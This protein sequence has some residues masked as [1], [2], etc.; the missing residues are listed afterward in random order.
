MFVARSALL[1]ELPAPR[2]RG[3]AEH[4]QGRLMSTAPGA[5][6]YIN[7]TAVLSSSDTAIFWGGLLWRP[8]SGARTSA[9]IRSVMT[10]MPFV[11]P[12]IACSK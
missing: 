7:D 3:E 9:A 1:R 12:L 10:P 11:R 6:A 8:A 4:G 5:A 2:D